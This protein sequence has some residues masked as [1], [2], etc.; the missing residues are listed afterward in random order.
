MPAL[1][2]SQAQSK[3]PTKKPEPVLAKK[4]EAA[5]LPKPE[6]AAIKPGE[7]KRFCSSCQT[8]KPAEKGSFKTSRDGRHRRWICVDCLAKKIAR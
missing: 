3:M 8:R 4:T 5:P 2:A 1:P 6:L 7:D